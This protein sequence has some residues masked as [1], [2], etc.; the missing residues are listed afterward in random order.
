MILAILIIF[1][2]IIALLVL[3]ELGHFLL[4]KKFGVDVEEFGVG[5]PPRIFGRKFGKTIYSLNL[6]PFGAFVKIRGEEGGIE[7]IRSFSQKPIWQR[8]LIVLGGIVSFF[9]CGIIILTIVA[10]VW[11]LPEAVSGATNNNQKTQVEIAE[12][13]PNSPAQKAGLEP[14]DIMLSISAGSIKVKAADLKAVQEFIN[15]HR[16]QKIILAIQREKSIFHFTLTPRRSPPANEGAMGVAL[17]RVALEK[18]SLGKAFLKSVE[19]SGKTTILVP[20]FLGAMIVKAIEHQPMQGGRLVGP[21]G[22]GNI[23]FNA[24]SHGIRSYLFTLGMIANFLAVSNLL[25]IPAIDGGKLLFLGIEKIRKKA[26]NRKVEASLNT[27]FFILLIGLMVVVT[28]QDIIRL[29]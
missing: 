28:V 14:G 17:V 1:F 24:L 8:S 10:Y 9:I 13:F 23:M 12:I 18:Y 26:I 3:H 2:S 20:Y 7:E 5:Y 25:P 22:I 11:G 6:L 15:A 4:A 27:T 19:I 16:G 21:I 29:F